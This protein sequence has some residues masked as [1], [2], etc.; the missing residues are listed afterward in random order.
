MLTLKKL[1]EN[2]L[3]FETDVVLNI[4]CLADFT[5]VDRWRKCDANFFLISRN[6]WFFRINFFKT[7]FSDHYFAFV[8][9]KHFVKAQ[10]GTVNTTALIWFAQA[11]LRWFRP[12]NFLNFDCR[13]HLFGQ[14]SILLS[15]KFSINWATL[16]VYRNFLE[17]FE[18]R[19]EN[20]LQ[21][22]FE[23]NIACE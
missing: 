17:M 7:D 11:S 4:L 6:W 8:S 15:K 1:L 12:K 16:H 23:R 5:C 20:C 3:R 19:V 9:S 10:W 14:L 22:C 13:V 21:T 18:K 2:A